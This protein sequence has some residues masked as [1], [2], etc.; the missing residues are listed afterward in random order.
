M[1]DYLGF[2]YLL[3]NWAKHNRLIYLVFFTP[4]QTPH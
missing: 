1:T 4:W 2:R 3:K